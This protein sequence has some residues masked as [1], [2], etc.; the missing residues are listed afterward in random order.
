LK[1]DNQ[2]DVQVEYGEAGTS[3][4]AWVPPVL[5]PEKMLN[6]LVVAEGNIEDGSVTEGKIADGAVT[7]D[8]IADGAVTEN[9]IADGAVTPKLADIFGISVEGTNLFNQDDPD[10]REG[11]SVLSSGVEGANASFCATG[12]IPVV[13]GENYTMYPSPNNAA[14]SAWYT[15]DKVFISSVRNTSWTENMDGDTLLGRYITAPANAAFLRISIPASVNMTLVTVLAGIVTPPAGLPYH[16]TYKV[17]KFDIYRVATVLDYGATGDGITDDTDAFTAALA[18]SVK[19]LYI[20]DG[21]Y[22][23]SGITI[24]SAN[25]ISLIGQ[26]QKGVILKLV[27]N[28]TVP[29]ITLEEG[30]GDFILENMTLAHRTNF[31]PVAESGLDGV[32]LR[33]LSWSL[34][35]IKNV[36]FRDFS[37]YAINFTAAGQ[38]PGTISNCA[39]YN[40]EEFA[41]YFDGQESYVAV[42]DCTF[43]TCKGVMKNYGGANVAFRNNMVTGC[44]SNADPYPAVIY[45]SHVP[46]DETINHGKVSIVA[47][48]INHCFGGIE[49]HGRSDPAATTFIVA[50][51]QILVTNNPIKCFGLNKAIIMGNVIRN[52]INGTASLTLTECVNCVVVGNVRYGSPAFDFGDGIGNQIGYN[53]E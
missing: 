28:P 5:N 13:A 37:N 23:L 17:D 15:V 43:K 40:G 25:P 53:S 45:C 29:L 34:S 26:S 41:L 44:G 18:S 12:F 2:T 27:D 36:T 38:T 11:Y 33:G 52:G 19:S 35:N 10:Y 20:P 1:T 21:T 9:K 39:F 48:T 8:K 24:T 4:I 6:A 14:Y 32:L 31:T 50:N 7:T 42:H 47:N 16:N 49:L 51:N 22:L 30:V 3:Y 46:D